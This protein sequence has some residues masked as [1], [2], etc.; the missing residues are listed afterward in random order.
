MDNETKPPLSA[1]AQ[2]LLARH[3]TLDELVQV[4]SARRC[5]DSIMVRKLKAEKLRLRDQLKAMGIETDGSKKAA[6]PPRQHPGN[7]LGLKRYDGNII[8]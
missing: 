3:R 1:Q 8:L 4:E 6:S 7:R 2:A 5:S